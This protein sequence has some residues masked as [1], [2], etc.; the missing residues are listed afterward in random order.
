M[1]ALLGLI[2]FA[3]G[4][5]CLV[6]KAEEQSGV[7]HI[8][9]AGAVVDAELSY[10]TPDDSWFMSGEKEFNPSVAR[11]SAIL[12]M[13]CY[14][15]YSGNPSVFTLG[16]RQMDAIALMEHLG[17]SDVRDVELPKAGEA[18]SIHRTEI[19]I[20]H[21]KIGDRT[22]VAVMIRG[23][24]GTAEE[25]LSNFDLGFDNIKSENGW[26]MINHEGFEITSGHVYDYVREYNEELGINGETYW[27]SGHSRG[28]AV[29]NLLAAKLID[30]GKRSYAYTFAAPGSTMHKDVGEEKYQ[31]IFNIINRDD[32]IPVVP[33]GSWGFMLYG[34]SALLS[35]SNAD[36]EVFKDSCTRDGKAFKYNG[37][38]KKIRRFSDVF[39][40]FIA[41]GSSPVKSLNT[42]QCVHITGVSGSGVSI[43]LD[44]KEAGRIFESIP[45]NARK[46]SH[47]V[48]KEDDPE[49]SYICMPPVA[50]IQ[51]FRALFDRNLT[52]ESRKDNLTLLL[53]C[54]Q[55]GDLVTLLI[56]LT[57]NDFVTSPHMPY[58]YYLL[59]DS[60][61]AD[62]FFAEPVKKPYDPDG[63]TP[64]DKE[65]S[66]G[67][68]P[69]PGTG[70]GGE[71]SAE[72]GLESSAES[73]PES[74]TDPDTESSRS[75][76][77]SSVGTDIESSTGTD[78][79]SSLAKDESSEKSSDNLMPI[80]II[81]GAAGILI[82][83]MLV[84]A[85]R[86]RGKS[87]EKGN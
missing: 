67:K 58:S 34:R 40:S 78:T 12:S 5:M 84:L 56:Q 82:S 77:E 33:L 25:W 69:D 48:V 19:Y 3:A 57:L 23:T 50:L 73:G 76:E 63:R 28:G 60:V 4:K 72:S 20:G 64:E 35:M 1:L 46:K 16:G 55:L 15:E 37:D 54:D 22:L 21:K 2:L 26:D 30:D 83:A 86:S 45:E 81:C 62:D 59:A 10:D 27:I 13:L 39:A 24:N 31:S 52:A 7:Y 47:L 41:K 68:D 49:K 42:L 36:K 66:A 53:N 44:T 11:L 38:E 17:F 32:M 51:C 61:K 29:A 8:S 71:S 9:Q 85:V 18:D 79:E 87:R 6:A 65:S 80:I 14:K 74:G 75:G 43:L 70:P